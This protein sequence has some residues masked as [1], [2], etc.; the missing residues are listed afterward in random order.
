[1]TPR[2]KLIII[3]LAIL[4]VAIPIVLYLVNILNTGTLIVET[5]KSDSTISILSNDEEAKLI[6]K[7]GVKVRLK[8]GSYTIEAAQS[9]NASRA[10]VVIDK[11]QTVRSALNIEDLRPITKV[12]DYTAKYIYSAGNEITFLNASAKQLYKLS[13]GKSEATRYIPELYP[14]N[15]VTWIN[16]HQAVIQRDV[17]QLVYVNGANFRPLELA[18][19]E[20]F[21]DF[22]NT[23]SS[24]FV[25]ENSQISYITGEQLFFGGL[26]RGAQKPVAQV[27]SS[28]S[29]TLSND[30]KIL[31]FKQVE[32]GDH[33]TNEDTKPA[34]PV[35]IQAVVF[36]TVDQSSYKINLPS[37]NIL[38]ANWSA[39]GSQIF[40]YVDGFGGYIYN[41][42]SKSLINILAVQPENIHSFTWVSDESLVYF[43]NRS[44]WRYNTSTKLTQK[45]SS[46]PSNLAGPSTFSV[47]LDKSKAYFGTEPKPVVGAVGEIYSFPLK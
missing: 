9:D 7:G 42:L 11:R 17:Y 28:A 45:I 19:V 34:K 41:L 38:S 21:E 26:E 25:N 12:A 6:G 1:M 15:N 43:D 16:D 3:L 5:N 35:E 32:S 46:L 23:P 33:T 39:S 29:V 22:Y 2:I 44:I 18:G 30:G 10:T 14:I 37:T 20:Y 47:S 4:L 31:V 27:D 13:I 8:P 36:N 24:F 40:F